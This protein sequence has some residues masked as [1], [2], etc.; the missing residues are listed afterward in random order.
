MLLPLENKSLFALSFLSNSFCSRIL[1][2]GGVGPDFDGVL[3]GKGGVG[4]SLMKICCGLSEFGESSWVDPSV[5][6]VNSNCRTFLRR[7]E[8][9]ACR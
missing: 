8:S 4:T 3:L 9:E 7:L 6:F 5:D 1:L 2:S